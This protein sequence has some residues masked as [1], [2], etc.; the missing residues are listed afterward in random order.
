VS[1]L[2]LVCKSCGVPFES[3]IPLS[4]EH[5]QGLKLR[6]LEICPLCGAQAD[7]EATEYQD[8]D[9]AGPGASPARRNDIPRGRP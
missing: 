1:I 6:A 7:Y 9:P 8:P 4:R 3:G 5:L 2:R